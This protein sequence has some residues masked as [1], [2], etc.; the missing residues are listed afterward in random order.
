ML[1]RVAKESCEDIM[2]W[3]RNNIFD[4]FKYSYVSAVRMEQY[5]DNLS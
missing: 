5:F 2:D 4:S 1:E 3:K